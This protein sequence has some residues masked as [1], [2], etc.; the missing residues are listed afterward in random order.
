MR[1]LLACGERI[2]PF[3]GPRARDSSPALMTG[4]ILAVLAAWRYPHAAHVRSPTGVNWLAALVR[5]SPWQLVPAGQHQKPTQSR[6]QSHAQDGRVAA[7]LAFHPRSNPAVRR[8]GRGRSALFAPSTYN[9][10]PTTLSPR[11]V[12][13]NRKPA[14]CAKWTS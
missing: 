13:A 1:Q 4:E 7:E 8:G 14:F 9:G 11:L 3:G 10:L 12:G 2:F 6:R 5:A